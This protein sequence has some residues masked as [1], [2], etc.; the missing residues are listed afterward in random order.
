MLKVTSALASAKPFVSAHLKI[1]ESPDFTFTQYSGSDKELKKALGKLPAF[2]FVQNDL[3]RISP[4]QIF[5][6]NRHSRESENLAGVHVTELSSSR[7]RIEISGAAARDVLTK[8][9]AIDFHAREFKPAQFVMTGIHHV[10]VLIHCVHDDTFQIYVMRTFARA[11]FGHIT[12]AA[13][14]YA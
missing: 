3:L 14:E 6:L 12:D 1:A 4:T 8:C 10:A 7:T 5:K 9:A 2:G 13:L 11:I